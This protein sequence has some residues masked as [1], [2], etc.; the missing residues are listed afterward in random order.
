M[1]VEL[2]AIVRGQNNKLRKAEEILRE[3]I[4]PYM[5]FTEPNG[6]PWVI[7]AIDFLKELKS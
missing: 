4:A 1:S 7:K 3:A 5:A 2:A 6:E